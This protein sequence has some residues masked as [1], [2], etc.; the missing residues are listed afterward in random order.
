[1]IP[2]LGGFVVGNVRAWVATAVAL[3]AVGALVSCASPA[4]SSTTVDIP[5]RV[6]ETAHADGA[7]GWILQTD[8]GILPLDVSAA[9][10]PRNADC[11]T[12]RVPGDFT[13]PVDPQELFEAL[14]DLALSTD[15]ALAVVDYC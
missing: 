1:M 14:D 5:G 3:T 12:I 7:E 10:P 15:A 6:T 8:F 4:A 2:D 11:V 13:A 9:T